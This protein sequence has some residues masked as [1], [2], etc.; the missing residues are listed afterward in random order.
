M[1]LLGP[2]LKLCCNFLYGQH[3]IDLF[4]EGFLRTCSLLI[5]FFNLLYRDEIFSVSQTY[6]PMDSSTFLG[7]AFCSVALTKRERKKG[8]NKNICTQKPLSQSFFPNSSLAPCPGDEKLSSA[9]TGVESHYSVYHTPRQS[10]AL[11][12][13]PDHEFL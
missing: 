11:S 2:V 5:Y 6:L 12:L 3:M 13:P 1:Y 10:S 9:L 4:T 7:A 8:K